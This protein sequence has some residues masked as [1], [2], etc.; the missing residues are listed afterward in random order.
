MVSRRVVLRHPPPG[1][2]SSTLYCILHSA[3]ISETV[4]GF[5]K[6][7]RR[8]ARQLLRPPTY[9]RAAHGQRNAGRASLSPEHLRSEFQATAPR[10]TG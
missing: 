6:P 4:T 3:M 5:L 1:G 10:D 8:F 7:R 2:R 9:S